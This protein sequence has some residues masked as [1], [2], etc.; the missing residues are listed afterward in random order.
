M[1]WAEGYAVLFLGLLLIGAAQC[2]R[3]R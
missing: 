3:V 2:F 1:S